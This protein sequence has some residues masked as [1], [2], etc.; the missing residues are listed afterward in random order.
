M[1][2]NPAVDHTKEAS[3]AADNFTGLMVTQHSATLGCPTPTEG[4][5]SPVCESFDEELKY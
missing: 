4:E 3:R 5:V 1:E 2:G